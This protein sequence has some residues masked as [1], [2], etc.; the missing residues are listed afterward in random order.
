MDEITTKGMWIKYDC[1]PGNWHNKDASY[2]KLYEDIK[3][4][5]LNWC[6][7]ES[8][9]ECMTQLCGEIICCDGT[10]PGDIYVYYLNNNGVSQPIFYIQIHE[11]KDL[12]TEEKKNHIYFNGNSIGFDGIDNKYLPE[13]ISKLCEIDEIKNK[14]Y[15][16]AL[17]IR[18][19]N[20]QRLLSLKEKDAYTEED[21]LFLYYMAYKIKDSL[22]ISMLE[23][24][25]IIEDFSSFTDE[26][27]V[28]LFLSIKDSKESDKLSID[29]KDILLSLAQK[30]SLKQLNN[31]SDEIINNKEYIMKLLASFFASDKNAVHSSELQRY[32]P[33]KYRTD[34]DILEQIFYQYTTSINLMI[35]IWLEEA[36][37]KKELVIDSSY[38]YR[39][40]N[41]FLKSLI[42][43][44]EC[45]YENSLLWLFD[46]EILTNL[47]NHMLIGPEPSEEKEQLKDRSIQVLKRE[48]E[49]VLNYRHNNN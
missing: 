13:L 26:N 30:R 41:T 9:E 36:Q 35:A 3:D 21:L 16:E 1:E 12:W 33:T 14:H 22:A 49:K 32:L 34:I 25:N 31:A 18:Y 47:E 45:Y 39:L 37:N 28:K 24:R 29:S 23:N 42:N 27:K 11:F 38:A 40:I 48:R 8:K 6:I 7:A 5:H 46:D 4:F 43:R 2:N 19:S 17:K 10:K 15:I 20:Y 44:G